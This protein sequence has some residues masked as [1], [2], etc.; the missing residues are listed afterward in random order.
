MV[1]AI[2]VLTTTGYQLFPGSREGGPLRLTPVDIVIVII[3]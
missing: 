1:Y 3:G 2:A